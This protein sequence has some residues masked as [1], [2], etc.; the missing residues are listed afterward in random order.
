MPTPIVALCTALL[1][2]SFAFALAVA[3]AIPW[4]DSDGFFTG[5]GWGTFKFGD[6]SPPKL[7]D[8]ELQK[9]DVDMLDKNG[10][11]SYDGAGK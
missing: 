8:V 11:H 7:D 10:E 6:N 5:G 4:A 3:L 9:L 1:V 2:L